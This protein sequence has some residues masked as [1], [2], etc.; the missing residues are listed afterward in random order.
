VEEQ[1]EKEKE[2]SLVRY[3]KRRIANNKNFLCTITGPTGCISEDTKLYEQD[4]SVGELYR[5]GKRF[6][7]TISINKTKKGMG[8]Y[9]PI[10][11]KSEII[12][13]GKKEVYEIEL[14]NGKKVL[15]S[16]D[17]KFFTLEYEGRKEKMLSELKVGDKFVCY[18]KDFIEGFFNKANGV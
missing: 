15:A 1:I 12:P 16:K 11:S 17:H 18:N 10:K 6:I 4:K 8:T 9:Y 5:E 13:S 14:E 3:I 2:Y 7:D